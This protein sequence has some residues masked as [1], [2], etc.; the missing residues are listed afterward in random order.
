M[1]SEGSPLDVSLHTSILDQ[2]GSF[3]R[4]RNWQLVWISDPNPELN[5]NHFPV[6]ENIPSE[7]DQFRR[8]TFNFLAI[9]VKLLMRV[10]AIQ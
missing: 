1:Y 4:K 3:E 8:K 7:L 5:L 10:R 6:Q 9:A 2:A